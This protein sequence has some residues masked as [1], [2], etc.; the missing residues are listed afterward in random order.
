MEFTGKMYSPIYDKTRYKMYAKVLDRV[1]FVRSGYAYTSKVKEVFIPS[2]ENLYATHCKA[3]LR[4]TIGGYTTDKTSLN[5]H[6]TYRV[7]SVIVDK[8]TS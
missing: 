4:H 1:V 8:S 3:E 7:K 2:T 6:H 5:K